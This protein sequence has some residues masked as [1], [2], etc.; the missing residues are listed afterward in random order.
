MRNHKTSLLIL[1][2]II[3]IP[4]FSQDQTI[5][6]L[7]RIAA[8]SPDSP[9]KVQ[10]LLQISQAYQNTSLTDAINYVTLAKDLSTKI[11]YNEGL[12]NSYRF[13]GNYYKK[14]GKYPESLDAYSEGLNVFTETHDLIGQSIILNNFGSLYADQGQ[15]SK[16][17]DYYFKS[18]KLGEQANDKKR[19]VTA[20]SNIGNIYLNNS[21]TNKK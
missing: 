2:I 5:D 11:K 19:V 15:E 3:S 14:L 13:L 17:L 18:L 1:F 12:G 7:K 6:S 16:A 20:L 8:K 21:G 4:A 10:I 9:V